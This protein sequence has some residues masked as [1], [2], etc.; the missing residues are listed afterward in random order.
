M[1]RPDAALALAALYSATTRGGLR[2]CSVCVTGAGLGAAIFCDVIG[3][4]YVPRVASSNTVLPV[5]FDAS[6]PAPPDPTMVGAAIERKKA[7]GQP[8]YARG[9]QRVT[10]TSLADAV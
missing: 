8:Q 2:V 9:V 6:P 4:F 10:D 1:Q 5:G 3:R 7:D